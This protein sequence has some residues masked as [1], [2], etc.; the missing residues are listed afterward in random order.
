MAHATWDWT[1]GNP[2]Q[3]GRKHPLTTTSTVDWLQHSDQALSILLHMGDELCRFLTLPTY[4]RTRH[5]AFRR[6]KQEAVRTIGVAYRLFDSFLTTRMAAF[7]LLCEV[8]KR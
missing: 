3:Q 1:G 5:F 2:T 4:S 6:Y 8:L 7:T